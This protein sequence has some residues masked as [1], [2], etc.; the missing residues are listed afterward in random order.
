MGLTEF[1]LSHLPSPPARVLEVGCGEGELARA[2]AARDYEMTAIDPGAPDGP[3]FRRIKL[4]DLE[5][6]S[7]F[8]AVIA[9]RSLHHITDLDAALDKIARLAPL[10]LLEELAWDRLDPVTADWYERQRR[11]LLAATQEAPPSAEDW[12][13]EHVGLH[14][15]E[16][17]RRALDARFE[18]RHF[19][20]EP[21]L[22][23]YL[24]GPATE[25]LE[26]TLI[27][28]GAIQALGFRYVGEP[29]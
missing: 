17:M 23:R 5:E 11:V 29:R 26:R 4:E 13:E 10:L 15:Y 9:G 8:D 1:V 18:E 7:R 16:A 14:G 28:A 25:V 24:G 27:D 20:W 6:D 2:L 21:Y 12:E 3:I 19:S 22:Y